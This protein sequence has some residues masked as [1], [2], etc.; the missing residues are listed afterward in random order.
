MVKKDNVECEVQKTERWKTEKTEKY[1]HGKI[2]VFY[3]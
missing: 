1:G 3:T 2:S